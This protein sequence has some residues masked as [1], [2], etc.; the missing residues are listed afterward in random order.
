MR[1]AAK[2]VVAAIDALDSTTNKKRTSP[3]GLPLWLPACA[4][5]ATTDVP[6]GSTVKLHFSRVG[7]GVGR[8][9][10]SRSGRGG[11]AGVS[12]VSGGV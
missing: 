12:L 1:V 8:S 9:V 3:E 2:H 6:H 7:C 11:A 5:V 10:G 4:L